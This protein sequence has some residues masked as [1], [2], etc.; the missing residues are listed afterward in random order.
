MWLIVHTP[1][2]QE[3]EITWERTITTHWILP[4]VTH[5]VLLGLTSKSFYS[6]PKPDHHLGN[7]FLNSGAYKWG[8]KSLTLHTY[9]PHICICT[10]IW[11]EWDTHTHEKWKLVLLCFLNKAF[12]RKQTYTLSFRLL[13]K[14]QISQK[15]RDG[16]CECRCY[17]ICLVTSTEPEATKSCD[18]AA[19][20]SSELWREPWKKLE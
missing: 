3:A 6:L 14:E 12:S 4:A 15:S 17:N 5:F 13:W 7:K 9:T 11:F 19:D 8:F 10:Y 2:E 20:N 1:G 16:P 18:Q